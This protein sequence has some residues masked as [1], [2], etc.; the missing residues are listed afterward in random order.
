MSIFT[1]ASGNSYWRG[2]HYY[3]E[4][5]VKDIKKICETHEIYFIVSPTHETVDFANVVC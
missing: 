5:R 4:N 3:K 2:Y 1:K